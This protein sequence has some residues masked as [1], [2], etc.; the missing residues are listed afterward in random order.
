[1]TAADVAPMWFGTIHVTTNT[2]TTY[3]G[4]VDG[5]GPDSYMAWAD[6]NNGSL[7]TGVTRWAGDQRGSF[8]TCSSGIVSGANHRGFFLIEA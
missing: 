8:A 6:C 2:S 1:M 7:A 4:W 5:N 3:G